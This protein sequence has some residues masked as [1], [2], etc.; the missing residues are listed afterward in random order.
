MRFILT[1]LIL[2]SCLL[3]DCKCIVIQLNCTSVIVSGHEVHKGDTIPKGSTVE[4]RDERQAM[5]LLDVKTKRQYMLTAK[6][7]ANNR[8]KIEDAL[9][10][11]KQLSSRSYK[12][13]TISDLSIS[14]PDSIFVLHEALI[15]CGMKTDD[16]RFFFVQYLYKG[17]SINKR[18]STSE[19]GIILD[20]KLL[21]VDGIRIDA[22]DIIMD[23]Y[24]YDTLSKRV[25]RCKESI[26]FELLPEEI[27]I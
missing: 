17:E 5:R 22:S 14:I 4:W 3:A 21:Y 18:L 1:F 9:I 25:F 6:M 8:M 15:P 24:Y 19:D 13:S 23:M 2:L 26:Y 7:F 16:N 12:P 11:T 10:A 27:A 20:E